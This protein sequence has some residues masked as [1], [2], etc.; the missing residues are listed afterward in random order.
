MAELRRQLAAEDFDVVTWVNQFCAN[1][2]LVDD[3][4]DQMTN[5]TATAAA[6]EPAVI[7]R[8]LSEATSVSAELD[9]LIQTLNEELA[10]QAQM[11]SQE[12]MPAFAQ[13]AASIHKQT[14]EMQTT[15]MEIRGRGE[16][17]ATESER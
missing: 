16:S 6:I 3:A 17:S 15:I 10:S 1:Q 4:A 14:H 5:T 13:K 11:I 2:G 9:V 8:I 12:V 7:E